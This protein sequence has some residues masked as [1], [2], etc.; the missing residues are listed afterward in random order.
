[1]FNG[2]TC[3]VL[4]VECTPQPD[5]MNPCEDIM[6]FVWLRLCVWLVGTTAFLANTVA[7]L[8]LFSRALNNSV[9]KFLMFMLAF[10]DFCT[11]IYLLLLAYEDLISSEEYFNH[12]YTWQNGNYST[13]STT[14]L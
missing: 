6:G 8:V 11:A 3:R 5:A 12:A 2:V 10:A 7:M 14:K 4:N 13:F 9:P 1:M